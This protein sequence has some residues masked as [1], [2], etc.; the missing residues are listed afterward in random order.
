MKNILRA[1]LFT[2]VAASAPPGAIAQTI[3]NNRSVVED[4]YQELIAER[5][6]ESFKQLDSRN[7]IVMVLVGYDKL[8][9]L[10]NVNSLTQNRR[11][12]IVRYR[13]SDGKDYK[14]LVYPSSILIIK[15]SPKD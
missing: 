5:W 15:E 13:G 8:Y 4:Q 11:I 12:L 3:E 1:I 6:I 10:K 9:E 2:L 7:N 14:S